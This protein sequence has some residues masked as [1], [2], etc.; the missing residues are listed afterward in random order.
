MTSNTA[1]V[2]VHVVALDEAPV[3]WIPSAI[4]FAGISGSGGD[5]IP[6]NT[7][8]FTDIDSPGTVTVALTSSDSDADIDSV[9]PGGSGGVTAS[10]NGTN[11]MILTGTIANINAFLAGGYLTY[12]LNDSSSDTVTVTINDGSG[13]TD[14]D[15]FAF[16]VNSPSF[17]NNGNTTFNFPDN[18]VF[19][20]T[21]T[22]FNAGN[23]N[24]SIVTTWH[25]DNATATTY[26]GGSGT[27]TIRAVFDANQL[28]EV[29]SDSLTTV[30]DF[31]DGTPNSGM[32]L[33]SSGWNAIVSTDWETAQLGLAAPR[34]VNF[35]GVS[36]Q[37]NYIPLDTWAGVIG[38]GNQVAISGTAGATINGTASSDIMIGGAADQVLNG[39]SSNDVLVAFHTAANTLNGEG[40]ADLLLGGDG[41]DTL[42]G[43]TGNDI[44]AGAAG[45]DSF[46]WGAETLT[47]GNADLIVGYDFTEG[48]KINVQSL[49]GAVVNGSAGDYV[50]VLASGNDLL[51]QVDANGTA[52]G[53]NFTTAYTLLGANT[54][55]ADPVRLHFANQNFIMTDGGGV[56]SA[57]DPLILDLGAP[58]ITFSSLDRR[59]LVRHQRRWHS[60]PG[61]LDCDQR[62]HS[63]LRREWL[64]DNR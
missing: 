10:G 34:V 6:L 59:R 20:T 31:Y 45:A 33:D 29:L 43:G 17:P 5:D 25:H 44:L 38:T 62:R 52:G 63:G 22:S 51:V 26:S 15:T 58:G 16:G 3:I 9:T 46:I 64:R 1:T 48:D 30:R 21:T 39:G 47:S 41:N 19:N 57:A 35:G 12:Q 54:D 37:D 11:S 49:V 61:R 28:N 32:D 56:S 60:R 18:D 7:V 42:S 55:G 14:T 50:H 4:N 2:T 53:A 27:D 13:G 24:D 23:N 8:K 40:G 36:T